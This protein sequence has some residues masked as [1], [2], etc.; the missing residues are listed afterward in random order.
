M[1]TAQK[2]ILKMTGHDK[3][4]R[5]CVQPSGN[6]EVSAPQ[7]QNTDYR[8]PYVMKRLIVLFLLCASPAFCQSTSGELRLKVVDPS[9]VGVKSTVH[10]TS[11]A[12]GYQNVLI[13]AIKGI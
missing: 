8:D 3:G 11:E 5:W 4:L 1:T 12:N 10:I 9:G 13:T 2:R 6:A 7:Q